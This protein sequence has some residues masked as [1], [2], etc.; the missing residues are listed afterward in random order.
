[1]ATRKIYYEDSRSNFGFRK[2]Q[3]LAVDKRHCLLK[4]PVTEEGASHLT[5]AF[6][7]EMQ[8]ATSYNFSQKRGVDKYV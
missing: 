1:M 8:S 3:L 4:S 7:A 5:S 2:Y 6:A